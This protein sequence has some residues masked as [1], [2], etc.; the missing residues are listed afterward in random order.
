MY[1]PRYPQGEV[2]RLNQD[3]F[4]ERITPEEYRQFLKSLPTP[5]QRKYYPMPTGKPP[6]KRNYA[7]EAYVIVSREPY[8]TTKQ[9]AARM[10]C[11]TKPIWSALQYL[12]RD[13]MVERVR[14]NR[15][16]WHWYPS[17]R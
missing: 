16:W 9:I 6:V 4:E 3:L 2:L 14:G 13:R 15:G 10:G 11:S 7:E 12:Y 17:G 8:L 1:W 5:Q